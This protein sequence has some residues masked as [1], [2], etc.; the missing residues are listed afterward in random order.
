MATA[1]VAVCPPDGASPGLCAR[2]RATASDTRQSWVEATLATPGRSGAT[3]GPGHCLVLRLCG[4]AAFLGGGPREADGDAPPTT[5]KVVAAGAPSWQLTSR[6]LT[7]IFAPEFLRP[8]HLLGAIPREACAQPSTSSLVSRTWK[9]SWRHRGR[10]PA[11]DLRRLE[12]L[13]PLMAL[14]REARRR[15]GVPRLLCA[16]PM[17]LGGRFRRQTVTPWQ[18]G[19]VVPTPCKKALQSGTNAA[20]KLAEKI[21]PVQL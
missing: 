8:R 18:A 10:A 9:S 15:R 20:A 4:G 13:D 12:Q 14:G 5:T 16:V 2:P 6:K 7:N 1:H 21:G 3:A 19:G 17:F 11:E